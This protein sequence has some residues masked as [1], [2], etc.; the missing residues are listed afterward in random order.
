MTVQLAMAAAYPPEIE[1]QW[2]E[3]LGTVWQPV[4]YTAV[5]LQED[6]VSF[7]LINLM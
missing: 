3:G 4:P 7:A 2:G 5:P 6:Y 1:Q